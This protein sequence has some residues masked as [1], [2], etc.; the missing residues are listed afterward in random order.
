MIGITCNHVLDAAQ[1]PCKLGDTGAS[2]FSTDFS[3]VHIL[4]GHTLY[5]P[6]ASDLQL[7]HHSFV[8]TSDFNYILYF[9]VQV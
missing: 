2:K 5:V 8:Q 9:A 7:M 3:V 6:D 1:V 4:P